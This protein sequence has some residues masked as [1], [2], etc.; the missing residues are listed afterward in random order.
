[1]N[2]YLKKAIKEWY[3]AGLRV[4]AHSAQESALLTPSALLQADSELLNRRMEFRS[5]A[6]RRSFSEICRDM[7]DSAY[8]PN[9]KFY[10]LLLLQFLTV[11]FLAAPVFLVFSIQ[12]NLT[13]LSILL[14][15]SCIWSVW[16]LIYMVRIRKQADLVWSEFFVELHKCLPDRDSGSRKENLT[17]FLGFE[18]LLQE[19]LKKQESEELSFEYAWQFLFVLNK[20]LELSAF[21]ESFRSLISAPEAE[22]LMVKL[23][24]LLAQDQK[25]LVEAG[26]LLAFNSGKPYSAEL[27]LN[28]KNSE[29]RCISLY[30]E[31]SPGLAHYFC[32]AVDL[33]EAR[34]AER[35]KKSFLSMLSHD[36]R[37]PLTTAELSLYS[38]LAGKYGKLG[39][40]LSIKIEKLQ[41]NIRRLVR[42][43]NDI[44]N[45]DKIES[46][47]IH[48]SKSSVMVDEL[49]DA[50]VL[51]VGE[52]AESSNVTLKAHTS[53]KQ[54]YCDPDRLLQV[55]INLISNGIEF[56]PE[57]SELV[58][59]FEKVSNY[60]QIVV[61]DQGPGISEADLEFVFDVYR[62]SATSSKSSRQGVGLG[63]AIAKSL[64]QLHGGEIGVKSAVGQGSRF[65]VRIPE[66][67]SG[68]PNENSPG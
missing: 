52:Y 14:A 37:T 68:S 53:I 44:L 18:Q 51:A 67:S 29:P 27:S 30:A 20:D 57:G 19:L 15:V 65:W 31:W 56:S 8:L 66:A 48:I 1:M 61:Q 60:V 64:V 7:E 21:N 32:R 46:G 25:E 23:T 36:L 43:S 50:A 54:M 35:L 33:T 42:L 39:T 40:D 5:A 49:I 47:R 17:N 3:L 24:D 9:R 63:L 38:I 41:K 11:V 34:K 45:L 58:V 16:A 4:K 13:S 2:E 6:N 26:F 59:E 22:L 10:S 55:L 28:Q 62:Q 12:N